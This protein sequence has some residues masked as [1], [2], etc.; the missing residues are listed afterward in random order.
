[1]SNNIDNKRL[2]IDLS[3]ALLFTAIMWLVMIYSSTLNISFANW[4]ILPRTLKGLRGIIFAPFIHG[5]YKHIYSNTFPFLIL[6]T[7]LLFLHPKKGMIVFFAIYFAGNIIVWIIGRE[8]YHIGSSGIIFGMASYL[9]FYGI[10]SRSRKDLAIS[11]IVIFLYGGLIWEIMPQTDKT[12]SWEAH[13]GGFATGAFMAVLYSKKNI[14]I[15]NKSNIYVPYKYNFD[16]FTTFKYKKNFFYIYK[17]KKHY[18]N[19]YYEKTNFHFS[20]TYSTVYQFECP[21]SIIWKI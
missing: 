14:T 12:I 11:L 10:I 21:T 19:Q 13:L 1:M 16:Y 15:T 6:T 3:I 2:I 20:S 9:L 7:A 5:G 17:L 8:A 18:S 4:G